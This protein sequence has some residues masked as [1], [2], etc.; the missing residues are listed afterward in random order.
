MIRKESSHGIGYSVVELHNVRHIFAAAVPRTGMTLREQTQDA[1]GTIRRVIDEQQGARGSIV[2]QAVFIRDYS[3]KEE[4]RRL[5]KDFY[6][7]EL[8]ATT[9]IA[10]PPCQ[11]KLISIEALGVGSRENEV[12]IERRSEDLVITRHSGVSWIHCAQVVPEMTGGGVYDRSVNAFVAMRRRLDSAGVPFD[13]VIRT[14][15]YLGDIVGPEGETQRY[16]ELN[17]ARTD[18]YEDI[19]FCQDKLPG[20]IKG[21]VFPASTG[22]GTN[23]GDVVMSCIAIS[24]DRKD[25]KLIPLEN[26]FQTSACDYA[27]EYSPKS[28]KF[29]RAMAL[30]CGECATIFVSGTASIT[31]SESRHL[32]DAA[33]Q[34]HQTLDNIEALISERN[35]EGHGT[36]GLGATLDD[37]ALVRVYI[38]RQ[39]DYAQTRAACEARFGEVPT[40]YAIADVCRPELLVEI[41][42]VAFSGHCCP[43]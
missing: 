9:Y 20:C 32:D 41:E 10:Q 27:A 33:A 40:I 13:N 6:G 34:T 4:C 23:N 25:L 37:L 36:P 5:I 42:A 29:A 15:L 8:P 18:Y 17:R 2:H 24:T 38:K 3:L 30:S 43:R 1:L 19:P 16:K 39:E 22:I 31:D 11:G 7:S 21:P 12:E 26:P 28:P 14:W 35:F